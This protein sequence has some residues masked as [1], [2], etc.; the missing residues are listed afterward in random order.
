MCFAPTRS[1]NGAGLDGEHVAAR[2]HI[3]RDGGVVDVVGEGL[4]N[5]RGLLGEVLRE[6][7]KSLVLARIVAKGGVRRVDVVAEMGQDRRT[8]VPAFLDEFG[9]P[10]DALD[11][12]IFVHG[13]RAETLVV[14]DGVFFRARFR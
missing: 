10:G 9:K 6:V 13:D 11:A 1:G 14:V 7:R 3:P 8:Q 12:V 4:R 2:F 5:V